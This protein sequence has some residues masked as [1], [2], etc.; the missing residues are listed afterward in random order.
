MVDRYVSPVRFEVGSVLLCYI[1]VD[2]LSSS[3]L[4]SQCLVRRFEQNY[5]RTDGK[6]AQKMNDLSSVC[7]FGIMRSCIEFV[8]RTEA[9]GRYG[10]RICPNCHFL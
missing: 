2:L 4:T 8:A 5:G 1:F 7:V 3:C 10:W 9:S 6:I